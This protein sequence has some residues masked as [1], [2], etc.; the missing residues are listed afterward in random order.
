M[1]SGK[2]L[3]APYD[4][5]LE[6]YEPAWS[7]PTNASA[8]PRAIFMVAALEGNAPLMFARLSTEGTLSTTSGIRRP[9]ARGDLDGRDAELWQG[10]RGAY[11]LD[12]EGGVGLIRC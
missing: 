12:R 3:A 9:L 5:H 11:F 6:R 7:P 2:C 1:F 8:R 10:D 4:L